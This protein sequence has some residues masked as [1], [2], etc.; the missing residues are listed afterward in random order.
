MPVVEITL[1]L[2]DNSELRRVWTW[3]EVQGGSAP[4][5]G[6]LGRLEDWMENPRKTWP[7]PQEP[8]CYSATVK[9]GYEAEARE[10][11]ARVTKEALDV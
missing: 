10:W 9:R 6:E 4:E 11:F 8:V 7:R 1:T 2:A 5:L 3:G